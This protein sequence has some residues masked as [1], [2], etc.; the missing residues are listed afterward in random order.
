M[1]EV[2]FDLQITKL[3]RGWKST[4]ILSADSLYFQLKAEQSFEKLPFVSPVP[5][6]DVAA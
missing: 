3:V 1:Q 6:K 2:I 4:L 5:I